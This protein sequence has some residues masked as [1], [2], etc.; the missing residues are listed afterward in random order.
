MPAQSMPSTQ[1]LIEALLKTDQRT[2]LREHRQ[3]HYL[4]KAGRMLEHRCQL[5]AYPGVLGLRLQEFCSQW[6]AVA[7]SQDPKQF[8]ARVPQSQSFW[9]RCVGNETGLQVQVDIGDQGV[10]GLCEGVFWVQ[11]FGKETEPLLAH[12]HDKGPMML[13]S[14]RKHLQVEPAK[15]ADLHTPLSIPARIHPVE[16]NMDLR[17]DFDAMLVDLSLEGIT[18]N[19]MYELERTPPSAV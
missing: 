7:V 4:V 15:L 3:F 12:L 9:D 1:Q 10:N 5:Q 2:V 18:W 17:E 11:P 19:S 13:E 14:I 8:I 6:R 16:E